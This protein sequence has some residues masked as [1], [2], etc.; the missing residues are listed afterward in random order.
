MR[1]REIMVANSDRSFA[2]LDL[3]STTEK[4][5]EQGEALWRPTVKESGKDD[6]ARL[7]RQPLRAR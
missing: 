5:R 2:Q 6:L 7:I 4:E 3:H 1:W